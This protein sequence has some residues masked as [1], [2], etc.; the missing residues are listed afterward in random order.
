MKIQQKM[1]TIVLESQ[2]VWHIIENRYEE[3]PEN[4]E[5]HR[6]AVLE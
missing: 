4:E 3:A 2:N 5:D 1:K 6:I